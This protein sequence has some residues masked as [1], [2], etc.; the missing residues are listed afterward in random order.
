MVSLTKSLKQFSSRTKPILLLFLLVLIAFGAVPGYLSQNWP[1]KQPPPV[2][3]LKEIIALRKTGL[4]I[5]GWQTVS[6]EIK[7]VAGHKWSYQTI[8]RDQNTQAVLMILPQNGP[9]EQPQVEWV[10]IKGFWRW[11][12]DKYRTAEFTVGSKDNPN[13][14]AKVQA[15]Y[16]QAWNPNQTYA[17]LQWYAF[18][19]GG[20]PHSSKWFWADQFAQW[21]KQRVPWIAVNIQIP[22][23]PLGDIEKVWPLAQS[24]GQSVQAT[25]MAGPLKKK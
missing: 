8:Q 22:I 1:W 23:E 20:N 9:K 11:K 17:V 4:T 16:F 2:P 24:L 25:L 10:D 3:H 13:Q 12:T 7:Q 6:Q 18:P 15:T 14:T 5:P 19:Y 21:Q